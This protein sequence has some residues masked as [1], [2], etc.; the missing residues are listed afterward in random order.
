VLGEHLD[1]HAPPRRRGQ[2]A[3]ERGQVDDV[4]Q[5][6]V[7]Q[8]HVRR[9]RRARDVRPRAR[10]DP[11]RHAARGRGRREQLQHVALPVHAR[12]RR[13]PVQR[14]RRRAPPHPTSST[15]PPSPSST[16]AASRDA[17]RRRRPE[18]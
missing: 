7:A 5:H 9:S 18:Q 16:V 14:E 1:D 8:H 13:D 3:Q 12:H 11:V 10:H 6:V 17:S 15:V 2:G 4:V